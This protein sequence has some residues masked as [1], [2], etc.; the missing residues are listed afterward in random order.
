M[1]KADPGVF[2]IHQAKRFRSTRICPD[3]VVNS[4]IIIIIMSLMPFSSSD[5]D[6]GGVI[7]TG[8]IGSQYLAMKVHG[9]T[10]LQCTAYALLRLLKLRLRISD[11]CRPVEMWWWQR[12]DVWAGA[13]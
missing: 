5:E 1:F 6:I 13:G 4:K 7:Y 12:W 10:S 8:C 3:D 2:V 9:I 11:V